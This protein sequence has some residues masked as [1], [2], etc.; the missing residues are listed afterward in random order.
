MQA[1]TECSSN[2]AHSICHQYSDFWGLTP[3]LNR[4]EL[5]KMWFLTL[6]ASV[7]PLSSLQAP[8]SSQS[9]KLFLYTERENLKLGTSSLAFTH[10]TNVI[11]FSGIICQSTELTTLVRHASLRSK[12]YT[13]VSVTLSKTSDYCR[14]AFSV[15]SLEK[16][17]TNPR[18]SR[19]IM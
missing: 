2:S 14:F 3:L 15:G 10:T 11:T 19:R 1:A 17:K 9:N 12:F 16:R 13:E 5:L 6:D 18:D 7:N 4:S 8:W